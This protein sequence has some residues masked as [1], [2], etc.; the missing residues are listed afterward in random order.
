MLSVK[1][2][3]LQSLW[4]VY[5]YVLQGNQ[6]QELLQKVIKSMNLTIP[7]CDLQYTDSKVVLQAILNKW[8][9]LYNMVLSMAID[10]FPD[11]A[12]TQLHCI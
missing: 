10:Y 1:K 4:Q 12:S 8:I 5:E 3:P 2:N 11:P 7:S 6:G 9:P